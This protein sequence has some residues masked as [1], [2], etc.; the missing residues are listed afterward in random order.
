MLTTT[1]PKSHVHFDDLLESAPAPAN[2]VESRGGPALRVVSRWSLQAT[3][4]ADSEDGLYAGLTYDVAQGGVFVATVDT[5][6]IGARVE[7]SLTLADGSTVEA[8]G[9]VRWLRDPALASDGLPAGCG[10]ECKGLA[11]S[12]VRALEELAA[13]REPILWLAEVA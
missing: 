8:T 6:P 5:P 2:D 10:V 1:Q 12:V 7:L 4:T 13:R 9:V 3:L 11:L